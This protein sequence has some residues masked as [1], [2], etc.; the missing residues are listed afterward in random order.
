MIFFVVLR[1]HVSHDPDLDPCGMIDWSSLYSL[2]EIISLL[3]WTCFGVNCPEDVASR[4]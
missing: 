3:F 2:K 1:S 4:G